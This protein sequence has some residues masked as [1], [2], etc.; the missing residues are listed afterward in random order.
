MM[1]AV[2][3]GILG[4]VVWLL[5][6][7]VFETVVGVLLMTPIVVFPLATF[8]SIPIPLYAAGFC[9]LLG[10]LVWVARPGRAG[11]REPLLDAFESLSVLAV[12]F[13]LNYS[14][15]LLWPDFVAMGERLRD[16]AL[17]AS[18]NNSPVVPRE[19]WLAGSTLN[20]YLY[21]YR[22]AHF[23]GSIGGLEVWQLYPQLQSFTFAL[24]TAALFHLLRRY[25]SFRPELALGAAVIISYGSNIAGIEAFLTHDTN[26]WGPSRV[27]PGAINEFPVWSFLL[28]D[29]HPHFLN[30]CLAP[31]LLTIILRLLHG[32]DRRG[33]VGLLALI[34][35]TPW[36]FFNA[37]AW[38]VP[39]WMSWGALTVLVSAALCWKKGELPLVLGSAREAV[40]DVRVW[41]IVI[42][43]V[44]GIFSLYL[45]SRN[46]AAGETPLKLVAGGIARSNVWDLMRHWGA[47]LGIIALSLVWLR[48]PGRDRSLAAI[49]IGV[50]LSARDA[51]PFL[52]ALA[53]LSLWRCADLVKGSAQSAQT[54]PLPSIIIEIFGFGAIGFLMVPEILFLD[55]PYG[56][57]NE[58]MNTIFKIYSAAW[59]AIH[60]YAASLLREV[61]ARKFAGGRS[62]APLTILGGLAVILFCGFFV[63]TIE[64]RRTKERLVQPYAQGL[65]E[66]SR[67]F[68]GAGEAI[69]ELLRL[70]RGVVLE[71]QGP[72]YDYTTHVAT[73]SGNESFLGWANHVNLLTREYGEVSRRE[74]ATQEFFLGADCAAKREFL[75]REGIG[76]VVFGPLERKTYP[77]ISPEGFACLRPV[78]T[79]GS[80]TIFAP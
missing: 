3:L 28:G 38:E 13:L 27:I 45:S 39:L 30:L 21:W 18:V 7:P 12:F 51:L 32:G 6:L 75:G 79:R 80:Y 58:R 24:F 34:A 43:A 29:L 8:P 14:L 19:P 20:Y 22:F 65:S 23:L 16:Y 73:L 53:V 26:W 5:R 76:Y 48:H 72:A 17:L 46:I 49:L 71:A 11:G 66:I 37:N 64:L 44:W 78:V 70:P 68:D 1:I 15:C 63:R 25:A 61:V 2:V 52:T 74:K 4:C 31:F 57:E 60:L 77:G 10:F 42:A 59:F 69:Q 35:L 50:S 40:A 9:A 67:R 47:P 36:W 33:T 41:A 55:D 54:P 56:G 62:H